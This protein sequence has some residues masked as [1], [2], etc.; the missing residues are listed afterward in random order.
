MNAHL[1]AK[2]P[3]ISLDCTKFIQPLAEAN[4]Q[5]GKY[6]GLLAALS[7]PDIY[8]MPITTQ[9]AIFSSRIEGTYATYEEVAGYEEFDVDQG[10]HDD[11]EEI[12]NYRR[13]L[14]HA[15]EQMQ[16]KDLPICLRMLK[17][18]HSIL[19]EGVRGKDRGRGEFRRVQNFIGGRSQETARYTPPPPE[20]IMEYMDNWEKYLHQE[21]P[22]PLVQLAIL[23]AQFES[24]HPFVD[25]NGRVGRIVVPLFLYERRLINKPLFSISPY[26]NANREEYYDRLL[27]VTDNGDWEGWIIYFLE[28]VREQAIIT[29][30]WAKDIAE[31]FDKIQDRIK[32]E[33]RSKYTEEALSFIFCDPVFKTSE[34]TEALN[35]PRRSANFMLS[36]LKEAGILKTIKASSGQS[37]EILGFVELIELMK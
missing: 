11:L 31:L 12:I 27:A 1:P 21:G 28:A 36:K 14:M 20:M 13:A 26:I 7:I 5:L 8:F 3:I 2:L 34:F 32:E 4:Y 9:E 19:L 35:A 6:A 29:G 37:A 10:K 23:H 17:D 18:I 30:R 33:V 22:D 16:Y 15:I 25:G 24:I